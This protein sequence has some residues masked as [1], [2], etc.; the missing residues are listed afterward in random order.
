MVLAAGNRLRRRQDLATAIRGGRRAG[1]STLVVHMLLDPDSSADR[2]VG[3]KVVT[4]PSG[5]PRVGFVVGRGV[6]R[7]VARNTVRRRLRHLI[8][9]RLA[10]LPPNAHLVIRAFPPAGKVTSATLAA[11]LDAALE[12]LLGRRLERALAGSAYGSSGKGQREIS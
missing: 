11:D 12:R 7:A 5:G 2:P 3:G 9:D 8:K 10:E 1:R 4:K 6:G